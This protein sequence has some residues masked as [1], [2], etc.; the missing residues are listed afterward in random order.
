MG[1]FEIGPP[2]EFVNFPSK[3][4]GDPSLKMEFLNLTKSRFVLF[5]ILISEEDLISSGMCL[6]IS[7]FIEVIQCIRKFLF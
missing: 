4:I 6:I 3:T 2:K 7:F 5:F 1:A